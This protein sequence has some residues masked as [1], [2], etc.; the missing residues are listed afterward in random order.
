MNIFSGP[1]GAFVSVA[2]L[3][4]VFFGIGKPRIYQ[5]FQNANEG[6]L[7]PLVFGILLV[8][9]SVTAWWLTTHSPL[10]AQVQ[11]FIGAITVGAVVLLFVRTIRL[12][13]LMGRDRA[14]R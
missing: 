1:L 14:P 4:V 13:V 10:A 5:K 2:C 7:V 11:P 3:A 6:L 12:W 9:A 8:N